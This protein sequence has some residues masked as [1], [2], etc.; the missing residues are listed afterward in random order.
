MRFDSKGFYH[1]VGLLLARTRKDGGWTQEQVAIAIGIP[2]A[3]LASL[4]GGR[5]RV[6]VDVLW[7][8]AVVLGCSLEKLV[9]EQNALGQSSNE[10]APLKPPPSG[11]DTNST[12]GFTGTSLG[13][14][15][16]GQEDRTP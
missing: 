3:T 5:Q 14:G 15:G 11:W 9:P 8:A 6:V 13:V 7:R 2:R 10:V 12:V 4:E 1:E 16:A